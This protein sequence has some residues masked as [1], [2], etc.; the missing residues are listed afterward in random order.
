MHLFREKYSIRSPCVCTG[1]HNPLLSKLPATNGVS[2]VWRYTAAALFL[3]LPKWNP[4]PYIAHY[5]RPEFYG[6]LFPT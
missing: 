6:T 2:Q 3:L 1:K 4:I 5:F